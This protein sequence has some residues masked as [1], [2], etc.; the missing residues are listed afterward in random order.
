M[1][2]RITPEDAVFVSGPMSGRVL[3]NRPYLI[4]AT[5]LLQNR[6]GC[7]VLNTPQYDDDTEM[8]WEEMMILNIGHLKRATAVVMLPQWERSRG[9]RFER[10]YAAI[11]SL[12]ISYPEDA[13]YVL[14][15]FPA[16]D[17]GGRRGCGA[18]LTRRVDMHPLADL[19]CESL[20]LTP[21]QAEELAEEVAEDRKNFDAAKGS[22]YGAPPCADCQFNTVAF[23]SKTGAECYE[24]N[25]YCTGQSFQEDLPL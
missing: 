17:Q 24:F 3:A 21:E 13:G 6:I 18:S 11:H 20:K 19:Y 22:L 25:C 8:S 23:C 5:H 16:I 14:S 7:T 15:D 4:A 10:D 12:K 9:A 1:I 2:D